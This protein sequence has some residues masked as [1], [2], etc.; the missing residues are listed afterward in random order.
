MTFETFNLVLAVSVT[1]VLLFW[2]VPEVLTIW[3]YL[4]K[5]KEEEER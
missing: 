5:E 3:W 2:I 4:H 1:A